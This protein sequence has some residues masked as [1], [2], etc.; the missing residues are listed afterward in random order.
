MTYYN[1]ISEGYEEL[2]K[3]EQ[4]KKIELI[5][6]FLKPN[7]KIAFTAPRIK[8]RQGTVSCDI[9]KICE[10]T[11][12]RIFSLKNCPVPFPIIEARPDQIVER[13]I[14]ILEK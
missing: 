11:G 3:E 8:T 13:E 6:K 9:K 5:K 7:G 14:F 4:L 1:E 10:K 2:H 12:L